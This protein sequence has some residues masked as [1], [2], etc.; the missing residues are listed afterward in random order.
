MIFP[1]PV[2]RPS[3]LTGFG[4]SQRQGLPSHVREAAATALAT[5]INEARLKAIA[6]GV[7]PIPSLIS[8]SLLGYF[9]EA[10]IRR[11]RCA[12]GDAA[13]L[14]LPSFRVAY[15]SG[16]SLA[17]VETIIFRAERTA[18]SDLKEWARLLTHVMQFQRWGVEDFARRWIDDRAAVEQEAATNAARFTTWLHEK[19]SLA[20]V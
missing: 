13:P 8:R 4:R 14:K 3:L 2:S 15:G 18:Q 9:P 11:C 20:R 7:R 16:A 12:V 17:L 5:A 1:N 6:G 19:E 10:L